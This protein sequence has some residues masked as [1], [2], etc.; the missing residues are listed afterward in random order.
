MHLCPSRRHYLKKR[1]LSQRIISN[2]H[3]FFVD[4]R[5]NHHCVRE[6]LLAWVGRVW[7]KL[8]EQ[9]LTGYR[10][11]NMENLA[12]WDNEHKEELPAELHFA[13]TG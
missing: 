9:W 1:G 8:D 7:A 5:Y 4:S 6:I 2:I 12:D 10:Y 11:L 3:Y 13:A